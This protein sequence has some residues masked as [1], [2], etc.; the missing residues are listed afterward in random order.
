MNR[1]QAGMQRKQAFLFRTVDIATELYVMT[2]T[3]SRAARMSADGAAGADEAL[4]LA[5]LFCRAARRRVRDLFRDLWSND[6]ALAYR[7]GQ[8]T[9]EGRFQF[10]EEWGLGLGYSADQLRP[11]RVTRSVPSGVSATAA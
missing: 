11:V 10:L 5:D 6:D 2:V 9:L 1:Y 7:I 3:A 8:R 4:R